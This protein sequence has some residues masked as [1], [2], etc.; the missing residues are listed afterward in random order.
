MMNTIDKLL[1]SLTKKKYLPQLPIG[2]VNSH[3]NTKELGFTV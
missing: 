3:I 2:N 1:V